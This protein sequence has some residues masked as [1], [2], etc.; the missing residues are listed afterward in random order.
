MKK[1]FKIILLT[2]TVCTVSV[3]LF[4]TAYIFSLDEWKRFD[5]A[6]LKQTELSLELYDKDDAMYL[7]LN[8]G[9]ERI[10]CN[11]RKLPDHV[12]NAFIAIE[13][14]RFYNHSGIDVIRIA[15]A[16]WKDIRTMSLQEGAS[17]I[18]QQLIKLSSLTGEKTLS[19]KTNEI[20]MAIKAE[21]YFTKD[22]IL[23]MYL[24]KAYFG[25]GTYG[26]EAASQSYFGIHAEELSPAQAAVLS[27][28]I[29]SPSA[30][31]PHIDPEKNRSRQKLVLQQM[32][33][34]G[35]LTKKEYDTAVS[36]EI[37]LKEHKDKYHY[38]FY[39]DYVLNSASN[40]LGI[41]MS[42]LLSGGYKI[43]TGLDQDL[44]AYVE[45][46]MTNDSDFPEKAADGMEPECAVIVENA[47][48]GSIAAL[49]GGREHTARLGF[50]RATDMRRQ[51]GSAIKPIL[52]FTPA[53]EYADYST[54]S[55]LFDQPMRFGEYAPRNA[56]RT[57]RGWLTLRDTV[58]YSVN[59]P[60]VSLFEEIGI[61]RCIS[62]AQSVGIP[63]TDGDDH[64]SLCLG[65]FTRGVTPLELAGAYQPY[66]ND[67]IYIPPSP[68]RMIHDRDGN[69]VYRAENSGC[70]VISAE[71]AFLMSS[72]LG[73]VVEYGTAQE[74]SISN[75]P[76][77]AKT[78]TTSYDDA[79]NNKDAW[80]VAYNPDYIICTWMGFDKTDAAHSLKKG[81]TGGGY[82][83]VITKKIFTE[84]Y[85]TRIAPN[86]SRPSSVKRVYL[87]KTELYEN[88][89]TVAMPYSSENTVTEYFTESSAPQLYENDDISDKFDFYNMINNSD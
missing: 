84:L 88:F 56:G 9:E 41:T 34:N 16:A 58:A 42:E 40:Q 64:L 78:G 5:P 19:R 6:S 86:F 29:K 66:A 65:G 48:D 14:V 55:F 81:E 60:T 37:I 82:P 68:I 85:R 51:P 89:R 1:F 18:T 74:L 25:R 26:I 54:T 67:G 46:L 72:M 38:G 22:E 43:Y 52:V 53:L 69:I 49:V 7:T 80:V 28:T 10:M 36:E 75:I 2:V 45:S 23:E 76:L 50:S 87:D 71:T 70:Q 20:I 17:T 77:C 83:A 27:A 73:S 30:Y 24:N 13:D 62:Y 8:D 59:I 33:K 47:E 63:F 11:Y 21:N 39:T 4:M 12:K 61:D 44:Q 31:S 35:F 79:E 3:I 15:G 57:F 32:L